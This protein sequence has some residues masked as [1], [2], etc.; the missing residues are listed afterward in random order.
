[1]G[2]RST[3]LYDAIRNGKPDNVIILLNAGA[4]PDY[5]VHSDAADYSLLSYTILH[6]D[7]NSFNALL[8]A[9]ADPNCRRISHVGGGDTPALCD[10]IATGQIEMVQR[11]I[12]AGADVNCATNLNGQRFTALSCAMNSFDLR[13]AKL[14]MSHGA[15]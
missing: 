10:A 14:L 4:N 8:N 12:Q 2:I 1:M 11:L 9:H 3:P 7:L 6:N 13:I 5:I 15:K